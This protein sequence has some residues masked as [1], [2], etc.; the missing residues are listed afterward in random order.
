MEKHYFEPIVIGSEV[1]YSLARS[2]KKHSDAKYDI[3]IDP[4]MSFGTGHP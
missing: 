3:V 1:C 2:T 4:K